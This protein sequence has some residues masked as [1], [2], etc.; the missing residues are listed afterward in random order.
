MCI[1]GGAPKAVQPP[2]TAPPPAPGP[3]P[4]PSNPNPSM[5]ADQKRGMIANMKKGI[6]STVLTGPQGI[7]GAGPDLGRP[8]AAGNMFGGSMKT[9]VGQ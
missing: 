8:S 9:T 2:P 1:F 6:A 4:V 3:S 7:T 5:T